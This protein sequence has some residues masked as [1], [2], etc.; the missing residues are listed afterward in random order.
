[1]S[2][3][4]TTLS[5]VTTVSAPLSQQIGSKGAG[6][7]VAVGGNTTVTGDLTVTGTITGA[8]TGVASSATKLATARAINGVN[9]DG[10]APIT[11]TAAAGT[12]TGSTLAAGVT[13]SSLT[14][15]G[16]L[17]GLAVDGLAGFKSYAKGSLPLATAVGQVI[18]VSDATGAHVAG[19]LA[20]ANATGAAN[21]IDVTTGLAVA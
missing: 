10:T 3:N 16:T 15:V 1:M 6:I 5:A 19:S 18:Y 13:A 4:S 7:P 20:F 11:V 14:S 9:F 2:Q 17:T 8:V 12:L 21:W